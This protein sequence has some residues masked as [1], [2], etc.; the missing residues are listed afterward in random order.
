MISRR[1][2]LKT[3]VALV[4]GGVI[5]YVAGNY[6]PIT[7]KEV[8]STK[9]LRIYNWQ[10]YLNKEIVLPLFTGVMYNEKRVIVNT[11]YDEYNNAE[12]AYNK[13]SLGGYLYDMYN[14]GT[15]VVYKA[16]K[17]NLIIKLDHS[18]IPNI[19]K[20]D[21]FIRESLKIQYPS[22]IDLL[23]YG[24]PY[25]WGTTGIV[26]NTKKIGTEITS[27]KQLFDTDFL[28]R[29]YKR[30]FI[31]DDPIT[32]VMMIQVYLGMDFR[33]PRSYT[34][35]A[36]KEVYNVLSKIAPYIVF[37]TTDQLIQE[38]IRES[39]YAGI[40]W[41]GDALQAIAQ[42]EDLVYVVPEEGS[43]LWIDLWTI[44]NNA[45]E[46]DLSYEWINFTLDPWVAALNTNA[47][48]Y[49]NPVPESN[50]YI[51]E[52]ILEDPAVYPDEETRK[53]LKLFRPLTE[54]ET[55]NII[56]VVWAPLTGK[57]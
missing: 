28:T 3:S 2:L 7:Q 38:L 39:V 40:A 17:N 10:A 15:E 35:E 49:A 44:A 34:R 5:G 47:I 50:E 56:E 52:K 12:E 36:L 53:R 46:K 29:Y 25:M 33:D 20:L 4:A 41:N 6:I 8:A 31:I 27:L 43:D 14:L 48:W 1:D 22:N 16:I 23:N 24:V 32:T 18:K 57:A 11:I 21:P 30:I 55:N 51:P 13:L 37:L 42:K 45:R 26:Y 19:N 9:E 54:E